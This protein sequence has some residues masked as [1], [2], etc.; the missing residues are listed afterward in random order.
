LIKISFS[1]EDE[2]GEGVC[3]YNPDEHNL[4]LHIQNANTNTNEFSLIFGLDN[5]NDIDTIIDNL[6]KIKKEISENI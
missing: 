1:A 4:Y 6:N 3:S 5:L 2:Y